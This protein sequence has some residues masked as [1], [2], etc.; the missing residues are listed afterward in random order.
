MTAQDQSQATDGFD[1]VTLLTAQASISRKDSC[2]TPGET[3]G[4]T[5]LCRNT[6]VCNHREVSWEVHVDIP[7][8]P[9]RRWN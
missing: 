7:E 4:E 8:V 5:R 1:M 3:P 6:S 9:F 2:E